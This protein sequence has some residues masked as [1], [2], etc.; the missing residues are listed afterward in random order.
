MKWNYIFKEH[1]G[2]KKNLYVS[3]KKKK[4]HF[5]YKRGKLIIRSFQHFMA[6]ENEI[7]D[8]K[9]SMKGNVSQGFYY[10]QSLPS[11]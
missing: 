10:Q 3:K 5:G 4:E 1:I 7:V 9:Y 8:W 11:L 6:E 2:L